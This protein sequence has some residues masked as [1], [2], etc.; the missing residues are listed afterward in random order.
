MQAR[1]LVVRELDGIEFQVMV[2]RIRGD[3]ADVVYLDD[4]QIECDVPLSELSPVDP[5]AV[6]GGDSMMVFLKTWLEA[7]KKLKAGT[8]A[9][10]GPSSP[11][12]LRYDGRY[13]ADDGAQ[14]VSEGKESRKTGACGAGLRGIRALREGLIVSQWANDKTQETGFEIK[15]LSSQIE[16]QTAAAQK[17]D[18]DVAKL[19]AQIA[20]LD[21]L[22]GRFDE[23]RP[24]FW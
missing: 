14:I 1:Q 24:C 4:E 5:T 18:T 15:T 2:L 16:E 8:S 22:I 6:P 7:V 13:I 23:R 9:E 19:N 12:R 17:A 21:G 10:E 20:E 11:M 3:E